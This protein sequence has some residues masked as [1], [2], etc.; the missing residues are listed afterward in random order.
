MTSMSRGV[1]WLP[2]P[3]AENI[4]IR[5]FFSSRGPLTRTSSPCPLRR[6]RRLLGQRLGREV[7]RGLVHQGAGEV[8]RLGDLEDPGQRPPRAPATAPRRPGGAAGPTPASPAPRAPRCGTGRSGRRPA[9]RPRRPGPSV[10]AGSPGTAI[11]TERARSPLR[12]LHPAP[13]RLAERLGVGLAHAGRCP[14]ST[15]RAAGSRPM[16]VEHEGLVRLAAEPLL[17]GGAE[18][19]SGQSAG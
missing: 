4:P 10:S 17:G 3:T 14:T 11:A 5:S 7:A 12:G 8:R 18:Q 2:W 13:G 9:P 19:L 6:A 1:F 16:G 15:T